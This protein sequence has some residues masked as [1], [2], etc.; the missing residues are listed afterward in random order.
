MDDG[1]VFRGTLSELYQA[2]NDQAIQYNVP[3]SHEVPCKFFCAYWVL[4][5]VRGNIPIVH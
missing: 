2:V 3:P 4:A 1:T 5:G